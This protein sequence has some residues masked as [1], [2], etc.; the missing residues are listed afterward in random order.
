MTTWLFSA[1]FVKAKKQRALNTD[2]EK[3]CY[4][5]HESDLKIIH[6]EKLLRL[7]LSDSHSSPF[8]DFIN[9]WRLWKLC[10]VL[11]KKMGERAQKSGFHCGMD[12]VSAE[13]SST[14]D[15]PRENN[16]RK[17]LVPNTTTFNPE[18]VH[19]V[20]CVIR[21]EKGL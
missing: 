18:T 4:C 15:K 21:H 11:R 9:Q 5:H 7:I 2:L 13:L 16:C 19:A 6:H 3:N 14:E 8:S 12:E 10:Y 1:V 20:I 17:I